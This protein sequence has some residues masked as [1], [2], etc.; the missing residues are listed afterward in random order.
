M[1]NK[2]GII[3]RGE[4]L[5]NAR[6]DDVM[7]QVRRQVLLWIGVAAGIDRAAE[8]LEIHPSV[9]KVEAAR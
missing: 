4:L 3:E 7:K 9:E 2:I 1:C 6:V 5:V 8:L